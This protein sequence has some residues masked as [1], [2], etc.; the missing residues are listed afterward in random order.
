[1]ET[2]R[3]FPPTPRL[4]LCLAILVWGCDSRPPVWSAVD[5]AADSVVFGSEWGTSPRDGA[6]PS[7]CSGSGDQITINGRAVSRTDVVARFSYTNLCTTQTL[8]L[9]V[10]AVDGGKTMILQFFL[11]LDDVAPD[12]RRVELSQLKAHGVGA[13]LDNCSP[14]CTLHHKQEAD[15]LGRVTFALHGADPFVTVDLCAVAS[16]KVSNPG[17]L[18]SF[19]LRVNNF[20]VHHTCL[21]G[22]ASSCNHSQF[23][24]A[25]KGRCNPSGSCT[26]HPGSKKVLISGKCL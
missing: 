2:S 25:T 17:T 13:M 5:G 11:C 23:V 10:E 15:F 20:I 8:F 14:R 21:S 26:C 6:L 4:A 7:F 9:F 19:K 24:S 16:A 1:M 3:R 12:A 22:S 18:R